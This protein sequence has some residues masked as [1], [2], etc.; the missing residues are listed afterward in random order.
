MDIYWNLKSEEICSVSV[1]MQN[2]IM[3]KQMFTKLMLVV[4]TRIYQWSSDV[5]IIK[6][7]QLHKSSN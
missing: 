2:S 5:F 4:S 1:I 6:G 3:F 7:T